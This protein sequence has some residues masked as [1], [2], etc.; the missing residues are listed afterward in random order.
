[1]PSRPDAL[2]H[3]LEVGW[4]SSA[5]EG[6]CQPLVW[7]TLARLVLQ[8]AN[9][10]HF[11]S[12]PVISVSDVSTRL[13]LLLLRVTHVPYLSTT[14]VWIAVHFLG[15]PPENLSPL[16]E[17][18]PASST[19]TVICVHFVETQYCSHPLTMCLFPKYFCWLVA[20][21]TRS[22][23]A[24]QR[25]TWVKGRGGGF[26]PEDRLIL[27]VHTYFSAPGPLCE[28]SLTSCCIPCRQRR[29]SEPVCGCWCWGG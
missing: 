18:K 3:A 29:T 2:V 11:N 22:P 28:W 10:P 6:A 16:S 1:M 12:H 26:Y 7:G 27:L 15:R 14:R 17:H 25:V 4:W 20:N 24:T 9:V 5:S 13:S 23:S 8:V 21:K 19:Y